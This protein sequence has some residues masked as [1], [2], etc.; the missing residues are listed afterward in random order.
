MIFAIVQESHDPEKA[1]RFGHLYNKLASRVKTNTLV[2]H[3][4]TDTVAISANTRKEMVHPVSLIA[5]WRTAFQK[6][7]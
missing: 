2:N 4:E 7:I 3:N 6:H 5:H 1:H